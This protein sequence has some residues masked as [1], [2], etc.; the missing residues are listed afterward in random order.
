MSFGSSGSYEQQD[1]NFNYNYLVIQTIMKMRDAKAD[2]D[3][4]RYWVNFE[5]GIQLVLS[6]LEPKVASLVQLDYDAMEA[7]ILKIKTLEDNP[8]SQKVEVNKLR[9]NFAD[10]HR[11]FLMKCLNKIGIVKVAEDGTIDFDSTELSLMEKMVRVPSGRAEAAAKAAELVPVKL[12]EEWFL[13]YDGDGKVMKMRKA[14]YEKMI[15]DKV[16][17]NEVIDWTAKKKPAVPTEKAMVDEE[18]VVS[19]V[20]DEDEEF[21]LQIGYGGLEALEVDENAEEHIGEND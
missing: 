3:I 6:H 4:W 19:E 9:E 2:G 17:L 16:N 7:I 15:D 21:K 18:L 12:N 8:E 5:F 1:I 11:V 20:R 13:V 10:T 14:D